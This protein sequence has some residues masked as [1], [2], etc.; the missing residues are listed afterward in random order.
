[1]DQVRWN[2]IEALLQDALDLDT[3]ERLPF[4]R[5]ACGGDH[6]LL[7][8]LQSL[9]HNPA[10][11]MFLETPA[12][13]A[14]AAQLAGPPL[15][16][17]HVSHYRIEAQIGAG[18][19]GD[20]YRA[21]DES[22]QRT[23]A[24]KALPPEF[25][26][27]A[28]RVLRFENEAFAASRL[29][30]PNIITI[31]E[32]AQ[33][34][35]GHFI[36]TEHIEGE[37]LRTLMT[38]PET[39]A[40]R[41]LEVG[42]ALDIAIQVAAAV[43]AAH[44]AWII[45]RD[46]KPENIMVRS[47]GL[48][49]VL[50]FGIAKL[51]DQSDPP[52]PYLDRSSVADVTNP[53]VVLGTASYM[54]PEQARGQMLDGRTDLY[55]LGLVLREMLSGRRPTGS[56]NHDLDGV[57]RALQRI[58]RHMLEPR[59]EDRYSSASELLDD[60]ARARQNL[61]RLNARRMVGIGA[62]ALIVAV[63]VAGLAAVLSVQETWDERVLRDGHAAAA[64]QVIF[65]PD[66]R[67]LVS[68]GED[69]KV[70]V[71]DFA[72]R[73]RLVTLE[74]EFLKIAFSPDGSM[75]ASGSPNGTISIWET[76]TWKEVHV[77]R[78]HRTEVAALGFSADGKLLAS[79]APGPDARMILWDLDRWEKANEWHLGV[80]Y[81]TFV[82]SPDG[83]Q[84]LTTTMDIIDL[85]ER[86]VRPNDGSITANWIAANADADHVATIDTMGT[87]ALYRLRQKQSLAH[88]DLIA[89]RRAHQDHGRSVAFSPDGNLLA[90]AA[91]NIQI[92]DGKTLKRIGRFDHPAIVWSVAFSPDGRW[93]VSAHGDGAVLIWDL[94]EWRLEGNLNEHADAVRAVAFHPDGRSVASSGD[95]RTVTIWDIREG[96]KSAVF[97]DHQ[98]RVTGVAFSRDR[99]ILASIDL[100]GMIVLRN[101]G[102]PDA[103]S[104]F[105]SAWPSYTLAVSPDSRFLADT[106]GITEIDG[107]RR[108]PFPQGF[109]GTVY[110]VA[111]SNDG[112]L[113]AAVSDKGWVS[114][115]DAP[116]LR[117]MDRVRVSSTPQISVSFSEDGE[118]LV[119]GD[120]AGI[121]RLWSAR[122]LREIAIVGRHE[123]R[124][125]SV[126]F[127]PEGEMIASAG[128]D[129]M[130]ALWD[131][132]RR[133]LRGRVG[134]HSSPV[135]AIAFSPD[136]RRLI[137]GEHDHSVR[138]YTRHRDVWGIR[139]E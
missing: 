46:I 25:A 44:A 64:R 92:W 34:D 17:R 72:R 134:T 89:S 127:S 12:I 106:F 3:D 28:A 68:C 103:L 22:L 113:I 40:A 52:A 15:T 85:P 33:S 93:L 41:S 57:P 121:V 65:S 71:W 78:G 20:V 132:A 32:I 43:K 100:D 131:V 39:G 118:H 115:W 48:V 42:R 9:L 128:D 13:A 59:R 61:E 96:R 90:S 83:R 1:M 74:Q 98:T 67:L 14:V 99:R 130:I 63:V 62:F 91:E 69:G 101:T 70:I 133:K 126:A 117:A 104:T 112:R 80:S 77:L 129:K 120:D 87:I 60:L 47:D 45:H 95:D 21:R 49:K 5:R 37:T 119:T 111:F 125:K 81:G 108:L 38:D 29:N 88:R 116:S 138:V 27:D 53:G 2:R 36:V 18:G 4:L 86:T 51:H 24:L 122:P 135:Y 97:Q 109:F 110:G 94:V 10:A 31:Y 123:A 76:R 114:V 19:M 84:L 30:H 82:F 35:E 75:L 58:V 79:S 73:T 16:G 6:E 7:S 105:R 26:A 139:L 55:S 136:G 102:E 107:R 54:S 11:K 137:S 50:D 124:V 8:E 23:V 66:G 56:S